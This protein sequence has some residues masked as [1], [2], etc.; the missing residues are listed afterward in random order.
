LLHGAPSYYDIT[1]G[2]MARGFRN[3]SA[4]GFFADRWKIHS[5][6][7]LYYGLRYGLVTAPVEVDGLDRVPY[8]CDCNNFSP[9][10][11]F[12]WQAGA[13][14]TVRSSYSV[15]FS[16]IQPVTY[17]Q[18]RY[19]LPLVRYVQVQNPDLLEPLRGVRLDAGGRSAPT[20]L[21]GDL[22]SPY[23][24]QYNLSLERQIAGQAMLRLGYVGSRS[25]K[26]PNVYILNRAEPVAGI[27]LTLGTVDLR[28]PDPRFFEVRQVV[29]GGIGYFDAA[30]VS[31]DAPPHHGVRWNVTYTF[32]KAIDEGADYSSTAANREVLRAR[33]LWQYDSFGDKKGLSNFDSTHALLASWTWD[34]PRPRRVGWMSHLLDDWQLSSVTMLKSGTPLTLYIGSDAPGFGNVDGGASDRPNILDPSILG[35]TIDHPDTAGSIL[36]R[37][38]FA[39]IAAG[40]RRGS[41]GRGTF[42]KAGIANL[43][44]ALSKQWHWGWRREWTALVR[45]E[46]YNLTN[47]PQFDEPQR[48]LSSPAFGKITNTLN[49]GR[50]WQVGLRLAL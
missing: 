8:G 19:N 40:E 31:L 29:N 2:E 7:Q 24:H 1:L 47:T 28:R 18:I 41:I 17:Q 6:F 25:F 42:R 9:R 50:I 14:W 39:Y 27:P 37:D 34:L 15:S 36:R 11:A 23:S 33:S 22:V 20:L 30:Q 12:A 49:D 21:A 13:G 45:A 48:N 38:R 46:V 44:A 4:N 43:N 5:R 16:E 10:V 3:W 32:G 26:F 35:R